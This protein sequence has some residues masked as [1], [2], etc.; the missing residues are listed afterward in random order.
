MTCE[1]TFRAALRQSGIEYSGPFL[2]DGKLHRFKADGD[3]AK[4]SWYV[5]YSGSPVAGA[6]GCWKRDIKET[7]CEDNGSLTKEERQNVRHRRQEAKAKLKVETVQLQAKARKVAKRILSRSR[8]AVTLHRYLSRKRVKVFG[9]LRASRGRLVV[10]LRDAQGELHSL[11]FIDGDGVKRFLRGGRVAGCFF[12]LALKADG[13]LIIDEGYVTGASIH[14]ATG[15]AVVCAISSGNLLEVAKAVRV[16]FPQRE[17]IIAAD[18]DRWTVKPPNP[19]LTEATAAAKAIGARLAVPQFDDLSNKPTDFNDLA[20]AQGS[21]TVRQQID[22]AQEPEK[23]SQEKVPLVDLHSTPGTPTRESDKESDEETIAHLAA[24]SLLDYGRKRKDEAKKLGVS[25]SILESLVRAKRLLMRPPSDGDNLQGV[26]VKLVDVEPWPEPVKGAEI[27][28]AIAKRFE[29]YVVLPEGAADML[30]LWCA[31]TH[32]FKLFQKSPRL[33]IS[34]PLPECGKTTL[35]N[36]AS[37]FCAKEV[38]TD[39]MTTA[40]MFRLVTGHSPTILAD[41]CDKWLFINEE[42][43]GLIC[44]GHEKGGTVMRCEGDS[45]ELRKFGCYAPFVLA[46][47]GALPSQL[48][49]RSICIRLERAKRE[50]IKKR[51]RFDFEHVEYETEL[52][53]KLARWITDNRERIQVCDPKLPEHLFNRIEDNWRPLFA[54]AEVA[55]GDWPYRCA[56]ALFKLTTREDE[57]ESLRVMLL[58]DIQQVF[59]GERMFSKDLVEQLTELKD[60]P[61]PE[62]CRGNPIT[63]RWLAR[64]LVDFG[65]HSGN[66]RIG[67][68]QAKGYERA[69]F[70]DV[71]ARY[72]P[73]TPEGGNLSVPPS[74]TE[75]KPE[76][77]IRPKTEF[78]TDEKK[79]I[80]ETLGRWDGSKGGVA[81]K[82]DISRQKAEQNSGKEKLRL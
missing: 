64:N 63:A 49:S 67:E 35:R 48:H 19:G 46:A 60:R 78:G 30:A 24:L 81:G 26:A 57:R 55:G 80:H 61:W 38:R 14:K 66:I 43:R 75:V 4:N 17:I 23:I 39:N 27:L 56:G 68:D 82:G 31:H 16:L 3:H 40:V 15:Y 41:E 50:E 77:S 33:N 5:L 18:N 22:S 74:H 2:I 69:Q 13:P 59:T 1:E 20:I 10:P 62:I 45:N 21:E 6:Y 79:P 28:D 32:M 12:S 71:F 9:E 47:I 44:S 11:Q 8:P 58:A 29:D 73:E 53:R 72:V 70:D 7:W 42:L 52:N 51:S 36:C 25:E 37:L 76:N 34:A 65:I 54:I